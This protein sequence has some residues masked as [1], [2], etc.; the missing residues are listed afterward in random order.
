MSTAAISVEE[1][2][3]KTLSEKEKV[4]AATNDPSL[5]EH[6]LTLGDKTF[7]IV[8]L[9]YDEYLLFL[10]KLAPLLKAMASGM[11]GAAGK[12]L[13]IDADRSPALSAVAV[14]EYCSSDLPE[15]ACIVCR[16]TDKTITVREVK[17]L[18]KNPFLLAKLVLLQIQQ[19]RMI[20]DITDF[21]EQMFPLLISG[22]KLRKQ[23]MTKETL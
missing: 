5:A 16:A 21:F 19:N 9:E 7:K 6:S 17:R 23:L 14:I 15:L 13:G 2:E 12:D 22:Q 3:V 1:A 18:A 8:D 11:L 4:R 10:T 20:G